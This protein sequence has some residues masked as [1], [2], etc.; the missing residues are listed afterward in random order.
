LRNPYV[1]GG[2]VAGPRFYGRRRLVKGIVTG[3]FGALYV[4][5][6]RRSGKT[7]LL[8]RTEE[9]CIRENTP[10]LF[11]D[12]QATGRTMDG[13]LQSLRVELGSKA[14]RWPHLFSPDL[15]AARDLD[16]MAGGLL[17]RV[18]VVGTQFVLLL[19]EAEVLLDMARSFPETLAGLR[20]MG[21]R[22]PG[23]VIVV[24]ASRALLSM[25]QAPSWKLSPDTWSGFQVRYLTH[26]DDGSA[27]ALI[28]QCNSSV[29]VRVAPSLVEQIKEAA[30]CQPYYLQLLCHRLY[31]SDHSLRPLAESDLEVDDLLE[32]LFR[33]D[34]QNLRAEERELLWF[35]L[36]RPGEGM[37]ALQMSTGLDD[38]DLANRLYWLGCLGYVRR[39]RKRVFVAN[40]FLASWLR[41]HR[42][43][44]REVGGE[45]AG[46][47]TAW[48]SHS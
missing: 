25:A 10:C 27:G 8:R 32:S 3:R 13:L 48:T 36:N 11:L 1:C 35:V 44:L 31:Q 46:P 41:S 26:L 33:S 14:R 24:A 9:E 39:R 4:M 23:L 16:A 38:V 7:S 18:E 47:G 15:L 12:L 2:W 40:R 34:Y 17:D 22:C 43:E 19:D 20:Q 37:G 45:N 30:G 5:G 6:G 21:G 28:Q 42:E 29:P